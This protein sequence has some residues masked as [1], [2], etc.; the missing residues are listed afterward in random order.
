MSEMREDDVL[1]RILNDPDVIAAAEDKSPPS[2]MPLPAAEGMQGLGALL[3]PELLTKLPAVLGALSPARGGKE[4]GKPDQ[5]AELLRALKP[6]MSPKR[7]DAIDKLITF[8]RIGDVLGNF[9]EWR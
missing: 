8:G 6:Y 7:C 3:S 2:P 9:W 5:R 1:A 4:G